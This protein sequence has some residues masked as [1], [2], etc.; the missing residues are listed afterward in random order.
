MIWI[1]PLVIICIS[2]AVIGVIFWRK[3]PLLRV[4]DVASIPQERTR[5]KGRLILERFARMR[6]E[7]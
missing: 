1:I 2:L 5:D 6:A 4:I 3:L 7:N